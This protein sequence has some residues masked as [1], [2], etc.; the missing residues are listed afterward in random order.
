M[1]DHP[2]AR[3]HEI[4]IQEL[5]DETLI[6]DLRTNRALAL[7][8]LPSE[9]WKLC[10]GKHSTAEISGTL[11]GLFHQPV[12]E[13]LILF[14]LELLQKE[15][16]ITPGS[17][18]THYLSGLTRRQAVRKMGFGFLTLLPVI[19]SL[20][21]PLAINAAS[22]CPVSNKPTGCVC[23]ANN[24]CQTNCCGTSSAPFTCVTTQSVFP[25]Q[26]C[27]SNCECQTFFACPTIAGKPRICRTSPDI[28]P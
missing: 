6:Y 7:N 21:A 27:R 1:N 14:T 2:L 22:G 4:V 15:N 11:T 19:S 8:K 25:C 12:S 10:D 20:T 9:V 17:L 24:E 3:V 28:C 18:K 23:T 5:S 16:L 26:P 13:E